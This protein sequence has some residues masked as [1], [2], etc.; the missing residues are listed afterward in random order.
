MCKTSTF[1]F[2]IILTRTTIDVTLLP[3]KIQNCPPSNHKIGFAFPVQAPQ[4][5]VSI[6]AIVTACP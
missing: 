5:E 2:Q 4:P 1:K 3:R 6:D